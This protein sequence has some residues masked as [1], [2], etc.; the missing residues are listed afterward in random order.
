MARLM[1][2]WLTQK[3]R[4]MEFKVFRLE[5]ER[6][7]FIWEPGNWHPPAKNGTTV[8]SQSSA[9]TP[10]SRASDSLA[11]LLDPKAGQSELVLGRE[12]TSD[13][14]VDDATVSGR[15]LI[16]ALQGERWLVRNP[17]ST[18]GTWVNDEPLV[19]DKD[20]PLAPMDRVRVGEVTLTYYDPRGLYFRL[21]AG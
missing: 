18:N 8:V 10:A 1:L 9:G 15:H 3:Y 13:L 6:H 11:I 7:C 19:Q 2:S 16:L 12:A 4:P 21:K 17:G 5:F 14:V 20:L